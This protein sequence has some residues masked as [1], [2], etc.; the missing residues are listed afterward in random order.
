MEFL[1]LLAEIREFI[2][3]QF[4][5]VSDWIGI[6]LPYLFFAAY[7]ATCFMGHKLHKIWNA[8]LFFG[9]G[10]FIVA[11]VGALLIPAAPVELVLVLALAVGIIAGWQSHRLHH[12]ELFIYNAY[13]VFVA[14]PDLLGNIMPKTYALLIGFVAAIAVGLLAAKFQYVV[15]I[16]T[17]SI[18]GAVN[19]APIIWGWFG[20]TNLMWI[21]L[22][23]AVLAICGFIVQSHLERKARAKETLREHK[24]EEKKTLKKEQPVMSEQK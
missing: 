13:M 1:E 17:T 4:Q 20:V 2:P 22:T 8:F 21:G 10:F 24:K 14:L 19:A 15:T 16:T 18:S 12:L 9:I 3:Q 5:G 11:I 7:L 6:V 23:I